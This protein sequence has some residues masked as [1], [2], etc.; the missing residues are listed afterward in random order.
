MGFF[1]NRWNRFHT[2]IFV[3]SC[4]YGN[5]DQVINMLEKEPELAYT[6]DKKGIS[7]LYYAAVNGHNK[8]VD[9][10]LE[11]TNQPDDVEPT[12]RFTPLM[13]AAG[14]GNIS[15][16]RSLLEHGADP[17]MRSIEGATALHFAVYEDH[18]DIAVMLI[19]AG[20]D[21]ELC[22]NLGNCAVDLAAASKNKN[23]HNIFSRLI[24]GV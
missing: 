4:Q 14:Q 2:G 23:I 20:A 13:T 17:N 19:E 3:D 5:E 22:D 15:V 24:D 1:K 12:R 6:R 9:I 8:I 16:V 7:G 21:Y 11:I 18:A 10:L